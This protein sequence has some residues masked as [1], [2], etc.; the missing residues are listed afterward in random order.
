[1][2]TATHFSALITFTEST[3]EEVPAWHGILYA[4]LMW[5]CAQCQSF[6]LGQYFAHMMVMGL[7]I[8]TGI[9]SAVY[10]KVSWKPKF[11]H[12]IIIISEFPLP[13]ITI[14]INFQ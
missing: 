8:R 2:I 7:Q 12:F 10:R 11:P 9:I 5:V 3:E 1:M 14:V 13:L 4:V 6:L